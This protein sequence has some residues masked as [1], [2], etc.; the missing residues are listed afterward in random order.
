MPRAATSVAMSAWARPEE[1]SL[2]A[3]LRWFWLRPPCMAT[4][5]TPSLL[6]LL[7]EPV[8]AV[9]GAGEHD[10]V[11]GPL[12]DLGGVLDAIVALHEPEVVAGIDGLGLDRCRLRG[13]SGRAGSHGSTRRCRRRGWPRT[14]G[15]DA[16]GEVRSRMRRTAGMKPMSAMRSASSTTTMSTSRRSTDFCSMRSSSRP[17]GCH[18]HVDALAQCVLLRAVSARRRRPRSRSGR[19]PWR[20][21]PVPS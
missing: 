12:D 1:N 9:P 16:P 19:W 15:S 5:P 8:G 7:G 2:S 17:G 13:G 18:Q 21:E 14:A 6:E 10:R 20:A 3:R 11:A 4:A